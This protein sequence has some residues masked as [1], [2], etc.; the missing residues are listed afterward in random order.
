MTYSMITRS[1]DAWLARPGCPVRELVDYMVGAGRMR[2]AQVDA[3]KTYLFLKV[4][5]GG[6]PPARALQRRGFQQPRPRPA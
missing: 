4:A 1:R 3:V 2:D 5:H 6:R